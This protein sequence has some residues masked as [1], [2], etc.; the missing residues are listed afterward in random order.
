MVYTLNLYSDVCQL[1]FNKLEKNRKEWPQTLCGF[2]ISGAVLGE[3]GPGF[4][5]SE[6]TGPEQLLALSGFWCG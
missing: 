6:S 5:P 1:F 4:F 2:E 3:R